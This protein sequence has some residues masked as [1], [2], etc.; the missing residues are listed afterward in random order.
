MNA[1]ITVCNNSEQALYFIL[2]EDVNAMGN[3]VLDS[4]LAMKE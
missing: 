3:S 2:H 4:I 1:I